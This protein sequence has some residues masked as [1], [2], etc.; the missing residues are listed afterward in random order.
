MS[1]NER[2]KFVLLT[3]TF[4]P[5]GGGSRHYYYNLFKR[6]AEKGDRVSILTSKV[7]GWQSFDAGVQTDLFRISRSFKPHRNL[8]YSQLP[9]LVMPSLAAAVRLTVEKPDILHCGDLYPPGLIGVILRKVRGLPFI[10]YCHGE[11]ITLTDQRRFQP[12]VRDLVYQQAAAII[13]NGDFAIK[14]LLRIGMPNRKIYKI[15]PGVDTAV[16]HPMPPDPELRQRYGIRDEVVLM[17]VARLT[18]RKGQSRVLHALAALGPTVS[19]VKYIICGKGSDEGSLRA[20][21]NELG[22]QDRVVFAG[23]VPQEELNRHYNLAD[24]FV[25]P[26]RVDSGDIEGFGMV[27]LEANATAKPVIGGRSGGAAEAVSHGET[28]LLVDPDDDGE[29]RSALHALI[30]NADL[31]R[32]LGATGLSRVRSEFAWESRAAQ[33][34]E[35]SSEIVAGCRHKIQT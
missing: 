27:F 16:F 4:L 25:M 23:F 14:N 7:P 3:D 9:K 21:A 19:A 12:K 15:T 24:I 26:N 29:L 10:A 18:P 6:I 35:L 17:T 33:T 1:E 5:G 22:L 11:D 32:T 28:G 8:S 31:R 30:T 13:A 2:L 34:R 20:L